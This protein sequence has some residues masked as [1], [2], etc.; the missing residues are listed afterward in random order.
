M[1]VKRFILTALFLAF[2]LALPISAQDSTAEPAPQATEAVALTAEPTALPTLAPLNLTFT[3]LGSSRLN[4]SGMFGTASLYIPFEPA[5][6]FDAPAQ[7]TI[8]YQTSPLLTEISSLSLLVNGTPVSSI[9]LRVSDNI[10]T[11]TAAIPPDLMQGAGLSLSFQGYLRV[12][13]QECESYSIPGQWVNILPDS[14]IALAPKLSPNVPQL[15]DLS[16]T[17]FTTDVTKH[18]IPVLLVLPQAV[19]ADVLNTSARILKGLA[20]LS[21]PADL[22]LTVASADDVSQQQLAT[23]NVILLGLPNQ[24]PL[25]SQ[26]AAPVS[27]HV[28]DGKFISDDDQ[29]VP[30]D[31]AALALAASPWNPERT[32]LVLSANGSAGLDLLETLFSDSHT[33]KNLSGSYTFASAPL[34][35]LDAQPSDQPWI[36]TTTT[37]AQLGQF[38]RTRQ[39]LGV[40]DEYYTLYRPAG[41]V[42]EAGSTLTLHVAA[43]A[44]IAA[45]AGS[46]V[47][48]FINEIPLG[49]YPLNKLSADGKLTFDLPSEINQGTDGEL[50]QVMN[51]RI[52]LSNQFDQ[53]YC[54]EIDRAIGWMTISSDSSFTTTHSYRSTPD[55]QV[56]PYPFVSD[57]PQA[58]VTIVIPPS[59]QPAELT[60]ALRLSM[61]LDLFATSNFNLNI[62]TSDQLGDHAK[63]N[64][65]VLGERQRQPLI[66]QL[67]AKDA[68]AQV[69]QLYTQLNPDPRGILYT[70]VSPNDPQRTILLAFG[71]ST[72]SM[73][74]AVDALLTIPPPPISA[75][76]T[77]ALVEAD[78]QLRMITGL[79]VDQA[80]VSGG[81]ATQTPPTSTPASPTPSTSSADSSLPSSSWIIIVV[82]VGLALFL[83]VLVWGVQKLRKKD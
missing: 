26:L 16:S 65:I 50:P 6:A 34:T 69:N 81:G 78:K 23:S 59:P 33:L 15:S 27:D 4:L 5:W 13:D 25:L 28:R 67:L 8:H 57:V 40:F 71:A 24:Q 54:Q 44:A 37:F 3:D 10:Q 73:Q 68:L 83:I 43:S 63:D 35:S 38:D 42:F 12:T 53:G 79:P 21:S 77:L 31:H 41:W 46:Y 29:V 60:A 70:A 48:A 20:R 39:G 18:S 36:T 72:A 75:S 14:T 45:N 82:P 2:G 9:P 80:A 17:F 61:Y 66:D 32:V 76:G 22:N 58:P 52:Q 19:S 7:L 11:F 49:S 47:A 51:L 74:A 30:D 62:A 56:F 1:T 64:L 55:L